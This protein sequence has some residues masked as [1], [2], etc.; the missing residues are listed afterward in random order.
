MNWVLIGLL[1][2]SLITSQHQNEE[3]CL[4]RKAMLERQKVERATCVELKQW[5][6][7]SSG[8]TGICF[9]KGDGTSTCR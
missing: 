8:S 4:G 7:L 2:G 1:A 3:D 6:T 5:G 9:L